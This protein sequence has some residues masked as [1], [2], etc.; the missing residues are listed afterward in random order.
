VIPGFQI[1]GGDGF[2]ADGGGGSFSVLDYSPLAWYQ[3]KDTNTLTLS[4]TDVTGLADKSANGMDLTGNTGKRPAYDSVNESIQFDGGDILL[5]DSSFMYDAG[6]V[7]IFIVANFYSDDG[8]NRIVISEGGSSTNTI[9]AP[10]TRKNGDG[11]TVS[12]FIRADNKAVI[13]GLG[14]AVTILENGILNG[15]WQLNYMSDTGTSLTAGLNGVL[16]SAYSYSRSST[17]TTGYFAL[18]G[19]Y[20]AGN[21]ICCAV[22]VDFKEAVILPQSLST[23]DRQKFEGYLCHE[24]GIESSLDSGHPYRDNPPS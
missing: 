5:R 24:H 23:L 6:G 17:L 22:P 4:G 13:G 20:R 9:Y 16:G 2:A 8:N 11:E 19:L 1:L 7:V 12:A 3:V 15:Q 10:Y 14:S 18:S 21:N